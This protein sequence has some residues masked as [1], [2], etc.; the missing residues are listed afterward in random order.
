MKLTNTDKN[1][2]NYILNR[3]SEQNEVNTFLI[4]LL[5]KILKEDK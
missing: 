4:Q 1:K 2:I 5:K 3:L